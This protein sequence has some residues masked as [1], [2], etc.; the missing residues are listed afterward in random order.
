MSTSTT[1]ARVRRSCRIQSAGRGDGS[2]VV[3]FILRITECWRV[4]RAELIMSWQS[5]HDA[6]ENVKS[7][8]DPL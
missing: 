3:L 4:R 5:L 1:V 2:A 8:R 6:I 7:P